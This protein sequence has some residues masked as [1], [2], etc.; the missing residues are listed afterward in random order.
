MSL[1]HI[2]DVAG[3]AV[4]AQSLRLNTTASNLANA[5]SVAGDAESAYR[6]RHPVFQAIGQ[7]RDA[8]AVGVRTLGIVES[9][10]PAPVRHDPDHPLAN[11][12]GQVFGANVS[13]VAELTDMISAQRSYQTNIEVLNTA[14]TLML[15]TLSVGE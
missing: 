3:S 5:D 4:S 1:L 7:T 14:K 10:A 6:A 11:E 8:A 9:D 15:R 12:Q 13:P 2:F